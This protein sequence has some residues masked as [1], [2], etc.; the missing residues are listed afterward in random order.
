MRG[1]LACVYGCAPGEDCDV[2]IGLWED[3][4]E[5]REG[6][7]VVVDWDLFDYVGRRGVRVRMSKEWRE[8]LDKFVPAER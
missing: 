3:G 1:G 4:F 5:L 7:G 2:W 8:N 6:E